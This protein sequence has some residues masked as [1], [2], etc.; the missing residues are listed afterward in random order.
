MSL[1]LIVNPLTNKI[2]KGGYS[3]IKSTSIHSYHLTSF[4]Y[5]TKLSQKSTLTPSSI[6]ILANAESK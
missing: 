4:P 3:L 5:T 2:V 6:S 1:L